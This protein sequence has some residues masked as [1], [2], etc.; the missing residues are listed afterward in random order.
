LIN[1]ENI[2]LGYDQLKIL[3]NWHSWQDK[4]RTLLKRANESST[5]EKL[6]DFL[7]AESPELLPE[8]V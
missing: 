3:E 7:I 4:L 8:A 6:R 1:S 2:K 5:L